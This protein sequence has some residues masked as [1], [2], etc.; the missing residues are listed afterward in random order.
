MSFPPPL[1]HTPGQYNLFWGPISQ[2][3]PRF[4]PFTHTIPFTYPDRSRNVSAGFATSNHPL[5]KTPGRSPAALSFNAAT[6]SSFN[7]NEYTFQFINVIPFRVARSVIPFRSIM[8]SAKL[9]RPIAST[10][11]VSFGLALSV[12]G[13]SIVFSPSRRSNFPTYLP[14]TNTVA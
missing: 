5:K 1:N 13:N 9:I 8:N 4:R 3:R 2:Y 6:Q 11:I 12:L 10:R 14:S 7:G